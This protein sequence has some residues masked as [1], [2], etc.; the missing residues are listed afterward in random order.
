MSTPEPA[1]DTKLPGTESTEGFGDDP[2]GMVQ[3]LLFGEQAKQTNERI[4]TLERALLGAISDLSEKIDGQISSVGEDIAREASVRT[5]AVSNLRDR[6]REDVKVLTKSGRVT[7]RALEKA[8]TS[9]STEIEQAAAHAGT[10]RDRIRVEVRAE[11]NA[12]AAAIEDHMVDRA[13]LAALLRS[14]AD[15]LENPAR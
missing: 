15:E 5:S 1:A 4:D 9:L 3:G 2:L 7:E 12:R 10:E 8:H 13:T 11:S 14:T 6:L